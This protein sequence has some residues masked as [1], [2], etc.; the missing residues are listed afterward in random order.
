MS[1]SLIK[2]PGLHTSVHNYKYSPSL[3]TKY[4]YSSGH[5]LVQYLFLSLITYISLSQDVK[6]YIPLIY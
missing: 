3:L 6:H 1:V 5:S 2:Y 4:G